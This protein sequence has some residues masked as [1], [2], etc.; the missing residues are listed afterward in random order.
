MCKK[1]LNLVHIKCVKTILG[2]EKKK[3]TKHIQKKHKLIFDPSQRY[4]DS[5]H[6]FQ[7]PKVIHM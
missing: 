4:Q 2:E 3:I 1:H 5:R 7:N 6:I